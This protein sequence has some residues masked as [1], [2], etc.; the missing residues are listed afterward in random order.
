M[1]GIGA[2]LASVVFGL[3]WNAFGSGAGVRRWRRT[4]TRCDGAAVRRRWGDCKSK[5]RMPQILVTN[6]DGYR[7]Q[8]I[9][10][11]ADALAPLGK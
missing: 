9:V 5:A 7:S 2:L 10:A 8:G 6:D 11:L 4:V 3:L 1:L